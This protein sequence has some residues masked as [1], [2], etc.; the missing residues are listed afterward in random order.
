LGRPAG[1]CVLSARTRPNASGRLRRPAGDTL[2]ADNCRRGRGWRRAE[3]TAG[4]AHLAPTRFKVLRVCLSLRMKDLELIGIY[5]ICSSLE[6]AKNLLI[7]TQNKFQLQPICQLFKLIYTHDGRY[8][9]FFQTGR[10]A[11]TIL[12]TMSRDGIHGSTMLAT[13]RASMGCGPML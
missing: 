6:R 13:Q 2:T 12:P 7:I 1:P 5:A 11:M 9:L 4:G 8:V 3:N 10:V